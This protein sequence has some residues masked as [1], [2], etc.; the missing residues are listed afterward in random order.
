[1]SWSRS[2][3]R[4]ALV[5]AAFVL[6]VAGCRSNERQGSPGTDPPYLMRV[7]YFPNLTHSQALAGAWRGDFQEALG[8]DVQ[9]ELRAFHAGPSVVEALFAGQLELAYVGPNPAINAYVKSEGR[10]IRVIAGATSGGASLVVRRDAGIEKPEDLSEKR[11]A[12]PQRGN[13][14]DVALRAFLVAHGLKPIEKRGTVEVVPADNPQILS[15]F[16][17]GEIHGAWV[18]EPWATRLLVD[19]GGVLFLDERSLWPGGD[20]VTAHLVAST[21]FLK[22]RSDL[23]KIWIRTHLRLTRWAL[24]HPDQAKEVCNRQIHR[25]TG[26]SLAREVLDGAWSR[27]RV[28]C[29]PIAG[30]LQRSADSAYAVGFFKQRPLLSEIYDLTLLNEVLR[31]EGLSSPP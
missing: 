1:V 24:A 7:G 25:L 13:T 12:S 30:S 17:Q 23:A 20:F 18:P 19:G 29:D 11:I 3:C 21:S 4:A 15:L 31:E 8:R 10:A 26:H 22:E 9:L 16:R 14:Q 5:G 6:H 28:T 2:S 27:L